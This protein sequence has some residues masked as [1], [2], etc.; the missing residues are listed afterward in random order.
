M[1]PKQT[2][3]EEYNCNLLAVQ[4]MIKECQE[5]M[6]NLIILYDKDEV[7]SKQISALALIRSA[8]ELRRREIVP[9]NYNNIVSIKV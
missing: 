3:I 7:L 1:S 4:D 9:N 5:V 8:V 6:S 2:K